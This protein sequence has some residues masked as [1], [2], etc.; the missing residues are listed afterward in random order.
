MP[1]LTLSEVIAPY[2]L[3]RRLGQGYFGKVNVLLFEGEESDKVVKATYTNDKRFRLAVESYYGRQAYELGIG[4]RVFENG[5]FRDRNGTIQDY[6]I[7]ERLT[8]KM[9]V[10]DPDFDKAVDLYQKLM[11]NKIYHNDL[12]VDNLRY[13]GDGRLMVID[14]GLATG[15]QSDNY[16][17]VCK[18]SRKLARSLAYNTKH[19]RGEMMS[20]R[21]K[22]LNKYYEHDRNQEYEAIKILTVFVVLFLTIVICGCICHK[23]GESLPLS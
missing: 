8:G 23:D 10:K 4:P 13:H 15:Y 21:S 6:M 1:S 7:I 3:G 19:S 9:F 11:E 14:Y 17:N 5:T 16:E 20:K 2:T 22:W 18:C 12:K